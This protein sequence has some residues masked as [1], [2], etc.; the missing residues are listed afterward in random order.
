MTTFNDKEKAA[1]NK[2]AHDQ[3][4]EFKI[5]VRRNKLFALWAAEKMGLTAASAEEY[6]ESAALAD[7]SKA[8]E[9]KLVTRVKTDLAA[10]GVVV[11]EEDIREELKLLLASARQQFE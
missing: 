5:R 11:A 6:A 4:T 2:Y 10:K 8:G 3:E 7:L 1:E 9:E